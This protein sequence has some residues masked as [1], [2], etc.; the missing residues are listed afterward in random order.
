[1]PLIPAV[2]IQRETTSKQQKVGCGVNMRSR[3]RWIFEFKASLVYVVP[4]QL[5]LH[6]ETLS[7]N[8]NKEQGSGGARL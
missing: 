6:C 5:E 1:M 8:N 7:Q 4:G 2:R 3:G